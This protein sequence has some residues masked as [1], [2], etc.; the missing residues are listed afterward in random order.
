[1][2]RQELFNDVAQALWE[3]KAFS[4]NTSDDCFHDEFCAY[5]G[6]DG[7][8][9]G[10]GLLIPDELYS[11]NLESSS[12]HNVF[13]HLRYLADKYQYT[14]SLQGSRPA[15]DEYDD[16]DACFV[17]SLQAALHDNLYE[18]ARHDRSGGEWCDEEFENA[19]EKFAAEHD[20]EKP[21]LE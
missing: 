20:L 17:N 15:C 6:A 5:R 2:K 16:S 14:K 3:Q 19:V 8:A 4:L 21:Q 9:C 1:M 11:S 13:E 12:A 10:I 18:T 7:T